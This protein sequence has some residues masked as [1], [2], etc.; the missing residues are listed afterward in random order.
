[1][2]R[3]KYALTLLGLPTL[4]LPAEDAVFATMAPGEEER[5]QVYDSLRMWLAERFKDVKRVEVGKG[6]VVRFS[7]GREDSPVHSEPRMRTDR[8]FMMVLFGSERELRS[9][10]EIRGAN[11]GKL[12]EM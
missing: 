3:S 10:C 5:D 12:D 4:V 8:V 9:M 1:M 7:W 6:Q 2:V 11:F